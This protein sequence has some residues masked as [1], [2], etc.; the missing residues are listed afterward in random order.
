MVSPFLIFAFCVGIANAH[1]AAWTKGMYCK[2]GPQTADDENAS[3][4][5]NPLPAGQS[6]TVE[7]A[8]NRAVT[9][10]SY[11]GKYVSEWVDGQ[12]HTDAF[13]GSNTCITDPNIHTQNETMASGTA[14]AI[15]YQSDLSQVTPENLVVFSVRYHTPWKRVTTYSVPA[16]LPACPPDGC[17]CAFLFLTFLAS[18]RSGAGSLTGKYLHMPSSCP[19]LNVSNARC[20]QPNMYHQGF[21]CKV[22]G[23]TSTAPVAA[24]KPPVWCEGDSSKCTQGAKQMIYWNQL[25]GNNIQVSGNDLSGQPKSPAYNQKLG[26]LDGAQNDIFA[27]P[28]QGVGSGP[29]SSTSTAPAAA[30]STSSMVAT[31]TQPSHTT[32]VRPPGA[33]TFS[34]MP[35]NNSSHC[36]THK[37]WTQRPRRKALSAHRRRRIDSDSW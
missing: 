7:I 28:A 2:N 10:L 15:S 21:K 12:A 14:F 20:G 8:D 23:A 32:S 35:T 27:A 30:S 19:V 33:A 22:T 13:R 34:P 36:S 17:I 9:T 1:L 3:S 4:P 37:C 18:L 16:G 29:G 5:V 31:S 6:F 26:F 25:D 24:A 11:N